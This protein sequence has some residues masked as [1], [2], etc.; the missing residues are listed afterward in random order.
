M[1]TLLLL[2]VIVLFVLKQLAA[3]PLWSSNT[4]LI[5]RCWGSW[6]K[7]VLFINNL[8]PSNQTV[9]SILLFFPTLIFLVPRGFFAH[10]SRGSILS[11]PTSG[12]SPALFESP[13]HRHRVHL[14]LGRLDV[15][16]LPHCDASSLAAHPIPPSISNQ[17]S[18]S[19]SP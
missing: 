10:R 13:H 15:V 9:I 4:E 5:N 12:H 16:H 2:M 18:I 3:G 11:S 17:V 7:N 8:F 14:H 6:W 19:H 1:P